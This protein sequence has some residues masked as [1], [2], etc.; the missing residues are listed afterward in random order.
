MAEISKSVR[1]RGW[2][3]IGL[4]SLTLIAAG[5]RFL[6]VT[7]SPPGFYIDEAAISAQV[8]CVQQSGHNLQGQHLPLFTEVLGGGYLT[9]AYLYPAVAWTTLFGGSIESLRLFTAFFSLLFLAGTFVFAKRLWRSSEAA[10][11]ATLAAAISPWVF[12][13]ARIAWDPAV[14]PAY[15]AWAFAALWGK[16]RW[17]LAAA[18]VLFS[19][20]AYSYPPMRVQIALCLPCAIGFLIWRKHNWNLFL[21][22]IGSAIVTSL[23]LLQL[24]L[25]GEIQGRFAMLSVFNPHYL[26]ETYGEATLTNGFLSLIKNFGLLLSPAYLLTNGDAN[27]RHSTGAFGIW[28]WLDILAI[29]AALACFILTAR[30]HQFKKDTLRVAIV[31]TCF[32][33]MGY[34]A[35]ILPAA[36]TWE[37]NPHALRSIGA[38]LF[39]AIG[40]GGS[41]SY[42]WKNHRAAAP[43]LLALATTF[44][45]WF[46]Y[47]YHFSYPDRAGPWFD[48]IV[49]ETALKLASEGRPEDLKTALLSS[50]IAYDE[51][52]IQYYDLL[53]GVSRCDSNPTR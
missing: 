48:S 46:Q 16:R 11:L 27:L 30:K 44:F 8:L 7:K 23:P 34:L 49:T 33:L 4:V 3:F 15:L 37:S 12:Q 2:L 38:T 41:L 45:V 21:L 5:A 26:Q 29:F 14:A 1:Q 32:V 47:N 43:T 28:S 36:M 10:W 39:L 19:L 52:A 25:S 35:G 9:P 51:M 6:G 22:P 20:A 42:L 50:G 31:T 24:T 18:G 40:T 13:F 53:F 17:E